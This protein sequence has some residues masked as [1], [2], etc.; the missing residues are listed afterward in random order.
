MIIRRLFEAARGDFLRLDHLSRRAI[1]G[2]AVPR[3][4]GKCDHPV[5]SL[6]CA[7]PRIAVHNLA[8]RWET[9]AGQPGLSLE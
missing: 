2:H 7:I 9:I 5:D 8:F 1:A 6:A 3:T 4:A